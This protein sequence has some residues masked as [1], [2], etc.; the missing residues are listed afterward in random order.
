VFY[1]IPELNILKNIF[2]KTDSGVRILKPQDELTPENIQEI[3]DEIKNSLNLMIRNQIEEFKDNKIGYVAGEKNLQFID[4]KYAS[5][6]ASLYDGKLTDEQLSNAV[7]ADYAVNYLI[8]NANVA[9]MFHG[10]YAQYFKG[11]LVEFDKDFD[12]KNHTLVD[13]YNLVKPTF[14]NLGK[15]LA[16]D[17]APG[18]EADFGTKN[19]LKVTV[20]KDRK[21]A[22]LAI[23]YIDKVYRKNHQNRTDAE[24]AATKA[25]KDINTSDAQS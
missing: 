1:T 9:Q 10:D 15:R 14:D 20:S 22:S 25:W 17:L 2:K 8:H 24:R 13:A 7:A 12:L 4:S 23:D 19:T 5:N 3:K 21:M 6:I 16:A 18:Y 11:D